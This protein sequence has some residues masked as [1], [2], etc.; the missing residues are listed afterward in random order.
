MFDV[1]EKIAQSLKFNKENWESVKFG[2]VAI[3]Q[4][5]TVDRDLSTLN[6]YIKGEHM[7]SEDLHIRAWG[8]LSDEYLGPAFI[9]RFQ[10]GDILYGSR[11]TYLRKVAVAH[12]D[13]ITSNTTFVIKANEK[14]INKMLLPYV[15]LSEGF[16]EHSV[17]NS[18]G[19]VNPYVNWKDLADYE[20]LLPPFEQQEKISNLLWTMDVDLQRNQVV[21]EKLK[22]LYESTIQERCL[23]TNGVSYKLNQI[24]D[25][26]TAG[27]SVN[28]EED[29]IDDNDNRVLKTSSVSDGVFKPFESKRVVTQENDRLKTPVKGNSIIISRMNTVDLVGANAFIDKDFPNLFLPDRLWQT[30]ISRMDIEV[31]YLWYILSSRVYRSRISELAS[32]TSN[33][34]KN[35]SK[36]SILNLDVIIPEV[37]QQVAATKEIDAVQRA[38]SDCELKVLDLISLRKSVIN[39]IF[40]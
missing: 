40:G 29:S 34:M 33:S 37:S 24:I 5:E 39:Q 15:M 26:L 17:K 11:R 21:R 28:S 27:V 22:I 23:N 38:V 35:I 31:K 13:G 36:K 10:A 19:S 8:E 30:S 12:F 32:G 3:Q 4:K 6:K 18:K 20:F 25:S 2:D 14:R 9:R 1:I 16:T 7:G